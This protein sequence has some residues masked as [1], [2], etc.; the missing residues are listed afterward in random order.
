[1]IH[2]ERDIHTVCGSSSTRPGSTSES[3]AVATSNDQLTE[4]HAQELYEGSGIAEGMAGK[5]GYRSVSEKE[6]RLVGYSEEQAGAGLL[7]PFYSPTGEISYQL[8]RDDPRTD[9]RGKPIKYETRSGHD[10]TLDVHPDNYRRLLE[11]DEAF[12]VTWG[13]KKA[14]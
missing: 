12:I 11:G 2:D 9:R 14:D 8:K 13:I 7:I 4:K 5:R 1:M 3:V 6:A 10:I